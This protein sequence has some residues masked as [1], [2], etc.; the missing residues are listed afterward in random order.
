MIPLFMDMR[1]K[2]AVVFGA[3]QVGLRKARY[4]AEEADV[5]VVSRDFVPGFE[6]TNIS[7]VRSEI[8]DSIHEWVS[9]ADLVVAATNDSTVNDAIANECAVK[10]ILCNR[11]DG[12]STFLIPSI[13]KR[14]NYT[15]AIST[16]G[17]SPGM[18]K[19]LRMRLDESLAEEYDL[20]ITL[21]EELRNEAKMRI[22]DQL[23]RE[24]YLW[25]VLEDVEVWN[26]I[27]VDYTRARKIALTR[28]VNRIGT[29]P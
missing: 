2:R 18:S 29:D 20:M 26:A 4:L 17:K 3:G 19:Y 9:K 7:L 16:F 22:P 14:D 24:R 15:I 12:L 23:S 10:G 25:E 28:L 1:G 5:T 8:S 6:G 27:K 21:Q 11:A 13:V